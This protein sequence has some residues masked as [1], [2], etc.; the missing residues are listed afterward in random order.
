MC[1]RFV[2]RTGAAIE[3]Y[4]NVRPH[5]F[6]LFDR[7]N[8]APG[9]DIPVIRMVHGERTLS[10]MHWGLIPS[11]AK[12]TKIGY[13]MINAR[14]ETVATKP[15]FRAAYSVRVLQN[16]F[17]QSANLAITDNPTTDLRHQRRLLPRGL[18]IFLH[19]HWY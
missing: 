15:A 16:G 18:V 2:S 9:T 19:F 6:K 13:K 11:W 17:I 3:R 1:G 8:V 14:A 10:M 7:Y 5:Q 12:D 4:F